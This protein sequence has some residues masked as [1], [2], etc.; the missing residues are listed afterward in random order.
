[1]L[2]ANG[3]KQDTQADTAVCILISRQEK[4]KKPKE[5]IEAPTSF[6][7]V[8]EQALRLTLRSLLLLLLLLLLLFIGC[9]VHKN[10]GYSYKSSLKIIKINNY[11]K[12]Y[13]NIFRNE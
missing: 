9:S 3:Q 12:K 10:K 11:I 2:F 1:L 4:Y 7:M 6:L 8:K 5:K 13:A